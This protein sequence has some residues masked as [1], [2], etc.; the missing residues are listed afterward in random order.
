MD[1]RAALGRLYS[2]TAENQVRFPGKNLFAFATA[3]IHGTV[4]FP[5]TGAPGQG[6]QGVNVVARWID[7]VTLR[8][9]RTYVATCVSGYLYRG[10]AGNSITGFQDPL[11][12]HM[13]AG[14]E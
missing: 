14:L 6:M 3:R 1:D 8:R 2:V 5:A 10:D 7:P 11:A 12:M 13:I 9:S 4:S